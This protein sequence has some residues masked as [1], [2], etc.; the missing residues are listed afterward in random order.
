MDISV[1]LRFTIDYE[2]EQNKAVIT[3]LDQ[4]NAALSA[5]VV[6]ES[7][8]SSSYSSTTTK[9][10]TV[11]P[12]FV[13]VSLKGYS[14]SSDSAATVRRNHYHHHPQASSQHLS[15]ET[16][17]LPNDEANAIS[18]AMSFRNKLE[19]ISEFLEPTPAM[20]IDDRY[21]VYTVDS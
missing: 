10:I 20:T 16:Y 11:Y 15:R 17:L 14:D 13:P 9:T 19:H 3:E 21:F 4:A 7:A 1:N 5:R 18:N 12:T 6:Y 2:G 8:D